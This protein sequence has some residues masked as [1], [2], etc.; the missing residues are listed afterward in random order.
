MP[1]P[2][3]QRKVASRKAMQIPKTV[4]ALCLMPVLVQAGACDKEDDSDTQE[5]G[6][7]AVAKIPVAA[8]ADG[9][10]EPEAAFAWGVAVLQIPLVATRR[11][12]QEALVA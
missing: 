1:W 2:T 8:W 5:G 4:T 9:Q 7:S 10:D 12:V 11:T 3:A 6:T